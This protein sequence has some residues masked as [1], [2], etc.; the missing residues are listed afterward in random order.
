MRPH[1]ARIRRPP[2]DLEEAHALMARLRPALKR[3]IWPPMTY[4]AIPSVLGAADGLLAWLPGYRGE[5]EAEAQS[6]Y[7]ELLALRGDFRREA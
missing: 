2:A 1:P 3:R 4:M 6:M 7:R 5:R